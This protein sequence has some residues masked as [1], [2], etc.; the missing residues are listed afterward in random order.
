MGRQTHIVKSYDVVETYY[1]RND[2]IVRFYDVVRLNDMEN[3]TFEHNRTIEFV[4][5][6]A[7]MTRL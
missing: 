4:F 2:H 6:C 7:R 5:E 1:M 3:R